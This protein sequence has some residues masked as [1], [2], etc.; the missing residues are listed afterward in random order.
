MGIYGTN[1]LSLPS[2]L[3]LLRSPPPKTTISTSVDIWVH[4]T[5][6]VVVL[7]FLDSGARTAHGAF[8]ADS[9]A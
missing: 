5:L 4:A 2:L 1:P 8:F 9:R 3:A 6:N 7:Q